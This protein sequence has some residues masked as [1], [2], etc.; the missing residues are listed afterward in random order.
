MK[1]LLSFLATIGLCVSASAQGP[2]Y[3]GGFIV[4]D[5]KG[6][7]ISGDDG[8][9]NLLGTV[10]IVNNLVPTYIG[11]GQILATAPFSQALGPVTIG[12]G[13]TYTAATSTLSANTANAVI[14]P[15]AVVYEDFS[16]YPV[17]ANPTVNQGVNWSGQT[18]VIEG[19]RGIINNAVDTGGTCNGL[20][21]TNTGAG[22]NGEFKRA[23]PWGSKWK[24]LKIGLS[25]RANTNNNNFPAEFA[26]GVCSGT[27]NGYGSGSTA[28]FIGMTSRPTNNNAFTFNAASA[29]KDYPYYVSSFTGYGTKHLGVETEGAL[30]GNGV[31][32]VGLTSGK[33]RMSFVFQ[34]SRGLLTGVANYVCLGLDG[35]GPNANGDF[36]S[37]D[38]PPQTLLATLINGGIVGGINY[39]GQ[40]WN[41]TSTIS[42]SEANGALDTFD[43]YWGGT[44]AGIEIDAIAI[45]KL[46]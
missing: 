22:G 5:S 41:N 20:C 1:K 27:V 14:L 29:T 11:G 3:S 33:N 36:N 35:Q 34:I 19:N 13:L 44:T 23:M 4:K 2:I 24:R 32:N 28:N 26:I 42:F 7:N 21:I 15:S 40:T 45:F 37:F 16:A 18:A 30:S 39:L 8:A 31:V 9:F 46:N 17:G 6:N 12:S 25:L 10:N 43:F 38:C